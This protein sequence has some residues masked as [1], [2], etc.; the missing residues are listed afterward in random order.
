MVLTQHVLTEPAL[1]EPALTWPVVTAQPGLLRPVSLHSPRRGLVPLLFLIADTGGGHRSAARAVAEALEWRYPGRFAPVLCDP[2][3]GPGSAWPL[4]MV[5]G[6]YGPVI[7]RVPWLWGAAYHACDSRPAMWLLG[8]TLLRLA[9]E[10]IAAAAREHQPA[11]LVSF[12]PLTGGAAVTARDGAVPAAPVIT[13]VTDLARMHA[14]WRSADPDVLVAPAPAMTGGRPRHRA[15]GLPRH[16][17]TGQPR[18]QNSGNPRHQNSGNPRHQDGGG[19]VTGWPPVTGQFAAGPASR[20]ERVTLRRSLGLAEQRFLVL[21]LG[22]GEGSGGLGRRA[23]AILRRFPDVSV[24]VVCGH[25]GRLQR[26]LGRRT[27]RSGGRLRVTG[28]TGKMAALLRCCDLLVTKA[29]PGAIAEAACCGAPML[30]SSR[31]PGQEA[32]NIGVVTTAGAGHRARS[33]RRLLAE[34]GALR[35]DPGRLEAMRAASAALA[36][37]GAAAQVAELIAGLAAPR[38]S[39]NSKKW[40]D[41][42]KKRAAAVSC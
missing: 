21:L 9:T 31:L 12:H 27:E 38:G 28:Y 13:V 22:G 20:A 26:R 11:A 35:D 33:V 30:L 36:R 6:W 1:T 10:P 7:R 3:G 5:T 17:A 32:G 34:I 40:S 24:I 4:R 37:P 42:S 25:N 41:N 39:D 16:R 8:R 2:L 14:A 15:T 29:G 19:T 23:R 18:H